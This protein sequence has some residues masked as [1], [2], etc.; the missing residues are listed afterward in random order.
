MLVFNLEK[1]TIILHTARILKV[2]FPKLSKKEHDKV[3]KWGEDMSRNVLTKTFKRDRCEFVW[4]PTLWL[5]PKS[6]PKCRS[7]YWDTPRRK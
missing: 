3:Y 7:P 4:R 1:V 2:Y 5:L 6:C